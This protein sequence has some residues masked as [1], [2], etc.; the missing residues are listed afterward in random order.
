MG[1]VLS[2]GAALRPT[3]PPS[4]EPPSNGRTLFHEALFLNSQNALG[5]QNLNQVV[6]SVFDVISAGPPAALPSPPNLR[7]SSGRRGPQVFMSSSGNA[8]ALFLIAAL[9]RMTEL[10]R[11]MEE[12]GSQRPAAPEVVRSIAR[13]LLTARLARALSSLRHSPDNSSCTICC[14]TFHEML[15]GEAI[16]AERDEEESQSK[17]SAAVG[18][19]P[20]VLLFPCHHAFCSTCAEQWLTQSDLCPNCRQS[21][22]AVMK[23][24]P[25]GAVPQWWLDATRDDP[26]SSEEAEES[27]HTDTQSQSQP[28]EQSQSKPQPQEQE[29]EEQQADSAAATVDGEKQVKQEDE[30]G[31][32]DDGSQSSRRQTAELLPSTADA[33]D[34]TSPVLK[35]TRLQPRLLSASYR[36]LR[37][38]EEEVAERPQQRRL[39]GMPQGAR[40]Q[41][42]RWQSDAVADRTDGAGG[43][44]ARNAGVMA[45]GGTPSASE[46]ALEGSQEGDAF[47]EEVGLPSAARWMPH[48]PPSPPS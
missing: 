17:S 33:G 38:G 25:R 22:T 48:T 10:L 11:Q 43:V 34:G 29:H 13:C 9:G 5:T 26:S 7:S 35:S 32:D 40:T 36:A 6:R 37:A 2:S 14:R 3:P 45:L 21:V 12:H 20:D 18:G 8:D 23:E 39:S 31:D 42:R 1:F 19:L 28:Q 41:G 24:S 44:E 47:V 15:A 30:T 27:A 4:P 46:T 16:L